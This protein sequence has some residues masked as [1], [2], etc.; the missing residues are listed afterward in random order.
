[1]VERSLNPTNRNGRLLWV[2][3]YGLG[4]LGYKGSRLR[5]DDVYLGSLGLR[6]LTALGA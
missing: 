1:M 4:C 3:G 2:L 6:G 5:L